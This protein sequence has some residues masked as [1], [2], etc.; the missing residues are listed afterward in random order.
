VVQLGE[1]ARVELGVEEPRL[2]EPG[3]GEVARDLE[4][5]LAQR[6]AVVY[7]GHEGAPYR[8]R[9]LAFDVPG[10]L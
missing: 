6:R 1:A 3:E 8:A 4:E 7:L 5:R 9:L 2:G 10:E